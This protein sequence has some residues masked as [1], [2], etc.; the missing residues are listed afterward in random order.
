MQIFPALWY[1]AK[2]IV[3][4]YN[5]VYTYKKRALN[6]P[7]LQYENLHHAKISCY[8]IL[9]F[10]TVTHNNIIIKFYGDPVLNGPE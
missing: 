5:K 1:K 8:M 6:N 10:T 4:A 3:C 7:S 2:K 9:H